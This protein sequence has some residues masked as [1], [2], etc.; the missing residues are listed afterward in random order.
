MFR[1]ETEFEA[2]VAVMRIEGQL[3]GEYAEHTRVLLAAYSRAKRL[4]VDLTEVTLVDAAGEA[5]LSLFAACGAEFT[6]ENLYSRSFCER[7]HLPLARSRRA[8][9]PR[10]GKSNAHSV[11]KRRKS[12]PIS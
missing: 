5:V 7:L 3:V 8:G 6:A 1:V 12:C 9:A 2:G 4:L 11:A 10:T